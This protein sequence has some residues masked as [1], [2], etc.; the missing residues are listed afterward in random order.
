MGYDKKRRIHDIIQGSCENKRILNE[1]MM[2]RVII[3]VLLLLEIKGLTIRVNCDVNGQ[4]TG[5]ITFFVKVWN[6]D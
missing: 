6:M 2:K 1:F 3:S 4:S 5:I